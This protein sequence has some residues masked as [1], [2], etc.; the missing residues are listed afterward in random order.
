MIASQALAQYLMLAAPSA[1]VAMT[2]RM[3]QWTAWLA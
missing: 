1:W 3:M 2:H